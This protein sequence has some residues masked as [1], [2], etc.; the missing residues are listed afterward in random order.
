MLSGELFWA[1][2]WKCGMFKIMVRL[3][4]AAGAALLAMAFALPASPAMASG[5]V[6]QEELQRSGRDVG[7]LRRMTGTCGMRNGVI[8]QWLGIHVA[9]AFAGLHGRDREQS[10][11]SARFAAGGVA[12]W[13]P[14]PGA[15]RDRRRPSSVAIHP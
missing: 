9:C 7:R 6:N 11:R 15:R 8:R 12:K 3:G 10:A 4:M 5:K 14:G 13:Q 2:Q 1:R